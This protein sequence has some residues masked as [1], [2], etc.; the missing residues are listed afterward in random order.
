MRKSLLFVSCFVFM[1]APLFAQEFKGTILGRITD[2]SGA[3]VPGAKITVTNQETNVAVDVQSNGEGN[4]VA[5]FLLPGRY[6]VA[7]G[8]A[9][10]RQVLRE[11]IIVQVNDR[12]ALDFAL[13]VGAIGEIV[14]VQAESPD[15][16]D[17]QRGSGP[18]GRPRFHG[19]RLADQQRSAT[20]QHGARRAGHRIVGIRRHHGQQ[21]ERDRGER[22]Q[23]HPK[24]Q[25]RH[26]RRLAGAGAAAIGPGRG[27][28]HDRR[29]A[30]V[31]DRH[32]DVRRKP[33]PFQRRGAVHHHEIGNQRIPR[34]RL[35]LHPER[36]SERQ[37][38]GEQ[39]RWVSRIPLVDMYSF[40][41]TVGGPVRLPK[42]DGRN[43][44]FFFFGY[45]K[46]RN[47]NHA[48][49]RAYVPTAAMRQG[50]FSKTL[51]SARH[52][53][54]LVRPAEHG[55]ECGGHVS[56]AR[57]VSQRDHSEP[58]AQSDRRRR[59][60]QTAG[61]Q[62]EPGSHTDQHAELDR[63]HAVS[64]GHQ[65]LAVA[66]RPGAGQQAPAFRARGEARILRGAESGLLPGRLQR[67]A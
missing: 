8:A 23:R 34:K 18:G 60:E 35:L 1:F 4:Y 21:P 67:P 14:T 13:Q 27:H 33:G 31:Q 54:G 65:E 38:L 5:P 9:G 22:R 63:R 15:A 6:K 46:D 62:S 36:G 64:A 41:G 40:G 42:Y 3:V 26:H 25:R 61:A 24:G 52:P 49:G 48:V 10:F 44:T 66:D 53:T 19:R 11:G 16:A 17:R 7:V 28:S 20:R 50:D 2:P 32:H 58:A 12:I 37:C 57:G 29:G 59:A 39:S 56:V 30:G 47:G 51:S 45:E 43:R 55:G